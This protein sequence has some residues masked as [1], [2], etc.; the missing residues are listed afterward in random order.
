MQPT[1]QPTDNKQYPQSTIRKKRAMRGNTHASTT[2]TTTT[3]TTTTTTNQAI[4]CVRDGYIGSRLDMKHFLTNL[5]SLVL[6]LVQ[7][8]LYSFLRQCFQTN[9]QAQLGHLLCSTSS[10]T[11]TTSTTS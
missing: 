3:R 2:T 9:T 11:T 8:T 7:Q 6:V 10:T 1:N 4:T 5:N